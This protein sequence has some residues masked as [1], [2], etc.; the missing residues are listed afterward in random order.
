MT[1]VTQPQRVRMR[2]QDIRLHRMP[3]PA[4]PLR[5]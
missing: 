4:P 5:L 3:D 1:T 2:N